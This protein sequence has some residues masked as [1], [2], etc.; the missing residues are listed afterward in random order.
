MNSLNNYIRES[1]NTTIN[2]T[3]I[4]DVS[5]RNS[6]LRRNS[7]I[8]KDLLDDA[9]NAFVKA[10]KE[11]YSYG[12]NVS[13]L[14]NDLIEVADS[15][16]GE[17]YY[18]M[19]A[20]LNPDFFDDYFDDDHKEEE[21]EEL[22]K[23]YGIVKSVKSKSSFDREE[24]YAAKF[25]NITKDIDKIIPNPD[26]VERYIIDYSDLVRVK[27]VYDLN[28]EKYKTQKGHIEILNKIKD[29]IKKHL[30]GTPFAKNIK[31]VKGNSFKG[32][33]E[34]TTFVDYQS[35]SGFIAVNAYHRPDSEQL[36]DF[37][38]F[39]YIPKEYTNEFIENTGFKFERA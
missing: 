33:D 35:D 18:L 27:I 37:V 34:L 9:V 1:L 16:G 23:K 12:T 13:S 21:V 4:N 7:K 26:I 39:I 29:I 3:K 5:I 31:I 36:G 14:T 30:S 20:A 15:A 22:I 28:D 10:Y 11:E 25:A 32:F 17:E 24:V 2:E 38:C 19:Q 8:N 6:I